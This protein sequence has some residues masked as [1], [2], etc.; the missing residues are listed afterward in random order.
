M[1]IKNDTYILAQT[2]QDID[3]VYE[4]NDENARKLLR[5][6]FSQIRTKGAVSHEETP[7]TK[8]LLSTPRHRLAKF[9]ASKVT[10]TFVGD[11][12]DFEQLLGDV[13]ENPAWQELRYKV[14]ERGNKHIRDIQRELDKYTINF[15]EE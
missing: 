15:T 12:S 9:L 14:L 11:L 4:K 13:R 6:K 7:D 5:E 8:A 10:T 1:T 2:P 3:R